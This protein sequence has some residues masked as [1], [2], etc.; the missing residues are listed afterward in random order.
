L[1]A[2]AL[3]EIFFELSSRIFDNTTAAGSRTWKEIGG[4]LVCPSCGFNRLIH[5]ESGYVTDNGPE[6]RF[7]NFV[8]DLKMGARWVDN[9]EGTEDISGFF[10]VLDFSVGD[11]I[12]SE[13]RRP[14]DV[15]TLK[16]Q[17]NGSD[18]QTLGRLEGRGRLYQSP[19]EAGSDPHHAFV[20]LQSYDYDNSSAYETGAQS[21]EAG[22][23][24]RFGVADTMEIRTYALARGIILGAVDSVDPHHT[25]PEDLRDYD[26]GPGAG[27]DLGLTFGRLGHPWLRGVYRFS[28]I[29]N[30]SGVIGNHLL[31]DASVDLNIPLFSGIGIGGY[32]RSTTARASSRTSTTST[33]MFRKPER[34]SHGG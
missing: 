21:V 29:H 24:S 31:Q 5:G 26:F 6:H 15:V 11:P 30:V 4:S 7:E 1:A 25:D 27:V 10:A 28:W 34:T 9:E 8:M 2:P 14:F 32:A 19:V 18:K 3:G 22:I 20:V 33:R 13:R 23:F 17:I 16:V 12:L